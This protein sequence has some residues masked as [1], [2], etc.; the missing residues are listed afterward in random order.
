MKV[1]AK[2][3]IKDTFVITG[4][5]LVLAGAIED[6]GTIAPGDYIEFNAYGTMRKR[7]I[8]GVSGIRKAADDSLNIGL[9]IDCLNEAEIIELRKWRPVD[10][11]AM[12][13]QD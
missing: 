13:T 2:F 9:L 8:N 3:K 11:P 6:D 12:V 7:R 4:R 5:G 1:K 10:E